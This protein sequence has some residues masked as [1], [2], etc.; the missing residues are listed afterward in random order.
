MNKLLINSILVGALFCSCDMNEG[1]VGVLDDITALESMD[2]IVKYR[3]GFYNNIRSI[4][5]GGFIYY[6]DIQADMFVGV[7]GNGNV[8]GSISLGN[9]NSVTT[10]LTGGWSSPWATIASVNYFLPYAEKMLA[11]EGI[12]NSDKMNLT[13]YIG[14][15]KWTRAYCYYYLVDHYCQAYTL[16]NPD[17]P[18]SG[19]PIVTVYDP[20]G[21]YATY[22]GRS[23][24]KE[25]FAQ[26]EKDL[27]D[28]Y[29]NLSA[30]QGSLDSSELESMLGANANY[31][32][33]YIVE[34]LQAR[35]ALL[36]GDYQT[37]IDKANDVIANSGCRLCTRTNYSNIWTNDTGHELLFV[38]YGDQNQASGVPAT[39][40]AW[41]S[42]NA[43]DV[44]Y[45]PAANA[46]AMYETNDIRYDWF[47]E[48]RS[49]SVEG[50]YHYAPCFVKF[51]GNTSLNTTS[52][53]SLKNLPKPFRL[54]E[55]YLIL[56]EAS[57]ALGKEKD[58]NDAL[59]ALRKGRIRS[60]KDETYGGT[61]LINQIREERTKELIGEGFRIS[62]LKRWNL[63]F[64][65]SDNYSSEYED[66]PDIIVPM[67]IAVKY[68][69][70]DY[71][72]V[73]PIP[74]HEMDA[75]PQLDGQQ[76]PGY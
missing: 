69:V 8:L 52:S 47:F 73:W 71:R 70:G 48:E 20:N 34:A 30:Y 57:A 45:I 31:L 43:E 67:G 10:D 36:K 59:N 41:L 26:I 5:A 51:P 62:D 58:A 72:Y 42:A 14:E 9:F 2:N 11:T 24:L 15:A 66:V 50:E 60:Y 1:P 63:S 39:G 38:L 33:T 46:L 65:R 40:S 12:S 49:I 55:T 37:A 4:T 16:A 75:N 6:S 3:S 18:A 27:E 7:R 64:S 32:N 21:D 17:A 22:P 23:T 54:S 44:K 29:T 35:I 53:N 76:N 19:V 13:R 68:S 25:S 61:E 28:A 56:A 74:K